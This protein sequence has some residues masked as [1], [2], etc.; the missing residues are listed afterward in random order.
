MTGDLLSH[1]VIEPLPKERVIRRPYI[2]LTLPLGDPELPVIPA[3][4]YRDEDNDIYPLITP[5]PGLSLPPL[6][7]LDPSAPYDML[8]FKALY[9]A[10]FTRLD[11]YRAVLTLSKLSKLD[12]GRFQ[13]DSAS[14]MHRFELPVSHCTPEFITFVSERDDATIAYLRENAIHERGIGSLRRFN[15]NE[16]YILT[17]ELLRFRMNQNNFVKLIELVHEVK[18]ITGM[19]V[20]DILFRW[21]VQRCIEE[22]IPDP[23]KYERIY[24]KFYSFCHPEYTAMRHAFRSAAQAMGGQGIQI[25]TDDYFEH[26]EIEIRI[27][28]ASPKAL[29]ETL[30]EARRRI[31][32]N[33]LFSIIEGRIPDESI[34]RAASKARRTR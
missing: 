5:A 33:A 12:A 9:Y 16:V 14:L 24:G 25:S 4:F 21:D 2:D 6:L 15:T 18:L 27:R 1:Y 31:D 23:E 17:K 28:G 13:S 30:S 34:P 8:R 19:P 26:K 32:L 7:V 3:I 10:G 11:F 29:A 22:D 20:H